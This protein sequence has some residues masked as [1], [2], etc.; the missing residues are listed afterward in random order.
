MSFEEFRRK[1]G[2]YPLDEMIKKAKDELGVAKVKVE[3]DNPSSQ[4]MSR[5]NGPVLEIH[6]PDIDTI[7]RQRPELTKEEAVAKLKAATCE[8]ISHGVNHDTEH[9]DKVV[10]DTLGCMVKHLT[11]E[12]MAYPYIAEKIRRLQGASR[13][14]QGTPLPRR[15]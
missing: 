14:L 9:T 2:G 5:Y 1:A 11:S 8:E 4:A 10:S 7:L 6:L 13:A 12:E 3:F 15:G